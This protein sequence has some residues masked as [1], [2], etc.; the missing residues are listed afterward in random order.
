MKKSYQALLAATLGCA[1]ALPVL[2]ADP[3]PAATEKASAELKA[4]LTQH[5]EALNKQDIKALMA[6]SY[7]HLGILAYPNRFPCLSATEFPTDVALFPSWSGLVDPPPYRLRGQ[8]NQ[9]TGAR[10][11]RLCRIPDLPQPA[12][13]CSRR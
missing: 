13:A 8:P 1:L 3:A 2:A 10:T 6:V 4:V 12:P 7:T 11:C 5:H 9:R